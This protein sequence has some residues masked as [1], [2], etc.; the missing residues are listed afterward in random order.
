MYNV[1]PAT[2]RIEDC[3]NEMLRR[4]KSHGVCGRSLSLYA[5]M[6]SVSDRLCRHARALVTC[7]GSHDCI[8]A[9]GDNA[10]AAPA[11]RLILRTS[12]ELDR[13]SIGSC[14]GVPCESCVPVL[15][16]LCTC[17]RRSIVLAE[18]LSSALQ[19]WRG[20]GCFALDPE[21]SRA[22]THRLRLDGNHV[23]GHICIV[24]CHV[25]ED[26]SFVLVAIGS[27]F[28]NS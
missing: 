4:V 20:S 12:V 17:H 21:S 22:E 5:V 8:Y 15:P 27:N 24:V 2:P 16:W 7:R 19:L 9:D 25:R 11:R 18:N 3:A 14:G 23:H 26:N 6:L 28:R 1:N 10:H 13:A